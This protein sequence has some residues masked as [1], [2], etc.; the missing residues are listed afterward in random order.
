MVR[1]QH[2]LDPS[3][4]ENAGGDQ[5][6]ESPMTFCAPKSGTEVER[7][8]EDENQEQHNSNLYGPST[9]DQMV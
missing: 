4:Q 1:E 3:I 7:E 9:K 5:A 2:P 6:F 8:R